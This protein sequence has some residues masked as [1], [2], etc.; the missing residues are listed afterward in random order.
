VASEKVVCPRQ[1]WQQEEAHAQEAE[2]EVVT[3]GKNGSLVGWVRRP[4][5]RQAPMWWGPE[6]LP[7]SRACCTQMWKGALW[8]CPSGEPVNGREVGER[9]SSPRALSAELN[10]VVS[11]W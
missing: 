1:A 5:L 11:Q 9:G 10:M 2:G 7:E 4:R 3:V 6:G 8:G